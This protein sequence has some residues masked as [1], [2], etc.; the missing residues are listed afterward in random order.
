MFGF[1]YSRDPELNRAIRRAFRRDLYDFGVIKNAAEVN[2]ALA[3]L[4]TTITRPGFNM[5]DES[6]IECHV[7]DTIEA[8]FSGA[9]WDKINYR[10]EDIANKARNVVH[11]VY[12]QYR[13]KQQALQA[14]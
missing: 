10:P 2:K 7:R 6:R 1:K 13:Q 11:G 3:R 5:T 8:E 12:G 14:A 4:V 9:A